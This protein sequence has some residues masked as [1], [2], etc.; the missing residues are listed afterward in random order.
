MP[1]Y[2]AGVWHD[3]PAS[4]V[5]DWPLYNWVWLADGS[6]FVQAG[7]A[8]P[9]SSGAIRTSKKAAYFS[10]DDRRYYS[11]PDL[12]VTSG[13]GQAGGAWVG[14]TLAIIGQDCPPMPNE[15]SGDIEFCRSGGM[16]AKVVLTTRRGDDHW[17]S[18]PLPDWLREFDSGTPN[19]RGVLGSRIVLASGHEPAHIGVFDPGKGTW[20]RL[21]DAPTPSSGASPQ[22]AASLETTTLPPGASPPP[23]LPAAPPASLCVVAG[24]LV[25]WSVSSPGS[26]AAEPRVLPSAV[27]EWW[28]LDGDA[29]SP[30]TPPIVGPVRRVAC[31]RSGVFASRYRLDETGG[32]SDL[33]FVD[34]LT[35][36]VRA[37]ADRGGSGIGASLTGADPQNGDGGIISTSR[38]LRVATPTKMRDVGTDGPYTAYVGHFL[39]RTGDPYTVSSAEFPPRQATQIFEVDAS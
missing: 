20:E 35:G 16:G 34:P 28:R 24:Q 21:P 17:E 19:V 23:Y 27:N 5:G 3:L 7:A 36:R 6:G 8:R 11:L 30:L 13:V 29:W 1:P 12:P 33:S 15:S 4:P 39:V 2:T 25:A 32:W 26:S 14:D 37:I 22:P 31:T 10:F 18:R 9:D 38:G